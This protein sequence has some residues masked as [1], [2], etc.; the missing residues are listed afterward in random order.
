[1]KSAASVTGDD[2]RGLDALAEAAGPAFARS[3]VLYTG[4][5]RI[6]FVSD[7]HV[8]PVDALWTMAVTR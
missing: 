5:E 2:L 6:A 1:V 7:R 3:I 4:S 8:L